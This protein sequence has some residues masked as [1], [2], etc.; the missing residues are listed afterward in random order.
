MIG[1]IHLMLF[2]TKAYADNTGGSVS[3][4]TTE[5]DLASITITQND[6]GSS[7]SALISASY[8][9]IQASGL[10]A[11]TFRLYV[12]GSVV[13]TQTSAPQPD[14]GSDESGSGFNYL[15]SGLDSTSGNII[16]K[17]QH[18]LELLLLL[19]LLQCMV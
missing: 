16:I 12:N 2:Y 8:K 11:T 10:S 7:F 17:L 18:N 13:K 19:K 1:M 3:N 4:T 9:E 5:T 15:A 6:L 14:A